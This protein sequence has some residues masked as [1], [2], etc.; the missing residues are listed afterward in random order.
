MLVDRASQYKHWLARVKADQVPTIAYSCPDCGEELE[1]LHPPEGEDPWDS[2]VTCVY[3]E[4]IHFRAAYPS[5]E[6]RLWEV[7]Q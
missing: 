5:G 1:T 2:M 4:R 7:P 3:C 6:V